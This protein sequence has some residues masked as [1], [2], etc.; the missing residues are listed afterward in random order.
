MP[1]TLCTDIPISDAI[2]GEIVMGKKKK[3][4][5]PHFLLHPDN[6]HAASQLCRA[7]GRTIKLEQP[8]NTVLVAPRF[9]QGWRELYGVQHPQ[10]ILRSWLEVNHAVVQVEVRMAIAAVALVDIDGFYDVGALGDPGMRW[11]QRR[12]RGQIRNAT[13]DRPVMQR[14]DS[15]HHCMPRSATR[16][17][18]ELARVWRRA[19]DI[20]SKDNLYPLDRML[21]T[22][23]HNVFH[24]LPPHAQLK[25]FIA[26]H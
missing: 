9:E 16:L 22:A 18:T 8:N 14:G 21:H 15:D 1:D 13:V 2:E 3:V 19:I 23:W 6:H 11:E 10:S 20:D 17:Q 7:F 24:T 12:F 25:F 5:V 4:L 26:L